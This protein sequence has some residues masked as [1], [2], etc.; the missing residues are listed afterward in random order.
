MTVSSDVDSNS[1]LLMARLLEL[2]LSRYDSSD[3]SLCNGDLYFQSRKYVHEQSERLRILQTRHDSSLAGH[4]G[5]SKTQELVCR[6]FWWPGM[7]SMIRD[8]VKSCDTCAR[9]KTAMHQPSGLLLPLPIPPR[10]WSSISMDFIVKLPKSRGSDSIL[11]VVDRFSKMAHFIPCNE[12]CTSAD[13]TTLMFGNVFKLHGLP[14]DIVSD[15][16]PQFVR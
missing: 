10:P 14:D 11:V 6:D 3:F 8:Y 16:G 9:S 7:H 4:F 2:E 13:V 5:I 12:S 1:E 15:R